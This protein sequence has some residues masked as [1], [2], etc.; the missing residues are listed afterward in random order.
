MIRV[1]EVGIF[2]VGWYLIDA[3]ADWLFAWYLWYT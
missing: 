2:I 3:L 1:L